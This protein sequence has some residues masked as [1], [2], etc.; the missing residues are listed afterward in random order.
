MTRK[1][2]A[3]HWWRIGLGALVLLGVPFV[4]GCSGR[5]SKK[6]AVKMEQQQNQML[7]KANQYLK[8]KGGGETR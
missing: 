1:R 5:P 8:E 4:A 6:Q 7:D 3:I 2:N